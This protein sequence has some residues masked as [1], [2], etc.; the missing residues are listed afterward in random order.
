MFNQGN[1]KL[2]EIV[3]SLW[4]ADNVATSLSIIVSTVVA[5]V[6]LILNQVYSNLRER[7]KITCEKIEAFY[8]ASISY[9]DACDQ[10]VTDIQLMKHR[11]ENG[12]YRNDPLIYAQFENA[13]TRMDM[14]HGLYFPKANFKRESYTIDKMPIIWSATT[15]EL[16]RKSVD[17]E[18]V[19]LESREHINV[20]SEHLRAVCHELMRKYMV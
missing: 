2:S 19:Y 10:L 9:L 11:C 17:S 13:I 8:E 15:G 14:L 12:Y 7:K 1:N 16:A 18:K 4:S 6:V 20:S 5:I 3:D